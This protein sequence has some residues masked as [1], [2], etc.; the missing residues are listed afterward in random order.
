MKARK[1]GVQRQRCGSGWV[2]W[3]GWYRVE[4]PTERPTFAGQAFVGREGPNTAE[5]SAVNHGLAA[6]LIY[7]RKLPTA[8]RPKL[9]KLGIDSQLVY[10]VMTSGGGTDL[11]LARELS[12]YLRSQ[13][14]SVGVSTTPIRVG[15]GEAAHKAVHTIC[16]QISSGALLA[17]WGTKGED[18]GH[19]D[20]RLPNATPPPPAAF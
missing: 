3:A 9:L 8:D 18:P 15:S 17:R 13:L 12:D 10:H 19:W 2:A 16:G 20:L 5:F 4:A 11:R 7:V 6:A 14:E 1:V